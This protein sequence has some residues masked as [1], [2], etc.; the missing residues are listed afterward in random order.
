MTVPVKLE[1]PRVSPD[2]VARAANEF[3]NL[4]QIILHMKSLLKDGVKDRNLTGE[5][6]L[7]LQASLERAEEVMTEL[8]EQAGGTKSKALIYPDVCAVAKPRRTPSS[9]A[10]EQCILLVDDGETALNL[11]KQI[12]IEAGFDVVTARSGFECLGIFRDHPYRFDLVLLD[13]TMPFLD[14]EETFSRLRSIRP[15]IA[16]VLCTGFILQ[17]RLDRLRTSGIAGF[18]RKPNSPDEIVRLVRST[19]QNLKQESGN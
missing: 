10:L 3:N 16:V 4:L 13:L 1:S 2:S 6:L 8:A 5:Y 14:G 17:E 18:L 12:L 15:D 11:A 9:Q 19:L 7:N